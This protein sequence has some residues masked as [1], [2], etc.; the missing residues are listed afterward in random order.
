MIHY[1]QVENGRG[2]ERDTYLRDHNIETYLIVAS[3]APPRPRIPSVVGS[4]DLTGGSS[5]PNGSVSKELRV[6][7]HSEFILRK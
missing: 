2:S 1:L 3:D 4:G 7:G 6:M 5:Q